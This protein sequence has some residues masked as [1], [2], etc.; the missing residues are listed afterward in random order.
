MTQSRRCN[1]LRAND[2]SSQPVLPASFGRIAANPSGSLPPCMPEIPTYRRD[3]ETQA[4]VALPENSRW[5]AN[6]RPPRLMGKSCSES[7]AQAN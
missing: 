5:P 6:P 1:G 4:A 2:Q 3:L 7:I